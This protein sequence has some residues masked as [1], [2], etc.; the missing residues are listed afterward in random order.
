MFAT[1]HQHVNDFFEF[2]KKLVARKITQIN[3]K[4][5][6]IAKIKKIAKVHASEMKLIFIGLI[7]FRTRQVLLYILE[8]KTDSDNGRT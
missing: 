8:H 5:T 4:I 1:F 6:Y 7:Q 3:R 2:T